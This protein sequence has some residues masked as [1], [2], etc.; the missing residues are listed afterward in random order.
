MTPGLTVPDTVGVD[1]DELRTFSAAVLSHEGLD[2]TASVSVMFVDEATMADLNLRHM[3]KT[4]ATDVLSF[5]IEDAVPGTPPVRAAGGPDLE[6]GDIVLCLDIVQRHATDFG[7]SLRS[8]LHL[9]VVHGV[10]HILGWDHETELEA[11]RMEARE[12]EHLSRAGME[13]R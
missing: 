10:L 7:V 8:E 12:A 1:E 11:E 2:D 6:L 9:M 3:G 13:R 4:G 5:P